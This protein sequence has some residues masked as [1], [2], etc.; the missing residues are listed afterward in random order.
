MLDLDY[1]GQAG[2]RRNRQG[3]GCTHCQ[4]HF[5]FGWIQT[6]C[7]TA[8][9]FPE[10]FSSY[11]S[12]LLAG[13]I[14]AWRVQFILIA[15]LFSSIALRTSG[16]CRR[17]RSRFPPGRSAIWQVN[18]VLMPA[19]SLDWKWS[20]WSALTPSW[21]WYS[22]L[23]AWHHLNWYHAR[24]RRWVYQQHWGFGVVVVYWLVCFYRFYFYSCSELGF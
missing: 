10:S 19:S 11:P 23:Q 9:V 18:I 1:T 14:S 7:W 15:I 21:Y 8:S 5:L 3:F 16:C 20:W 13:A 22:W 12:F 24:Q 4:S 6:D 2:P 17:P